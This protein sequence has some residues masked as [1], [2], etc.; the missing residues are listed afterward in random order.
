MEGTHTWKQGQRAER[1]RPGRTGDPGSRVQAAWARQG[2]RFAGASAGF[3]GWEGKDRVCS[4]PVPMAGGGL[5]GLEVGQ[6]AVMKGF[7]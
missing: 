7:M 6:E 5:E 2:R 3:P 4:H 1:G